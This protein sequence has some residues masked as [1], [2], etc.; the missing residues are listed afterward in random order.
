[1]GKPLNILIVEDSPDDV[2]LLLAELRRAGID[3]KWKRVETEPDFRAEIKKI[4]DIILS[5]YSMPQFN[6]LRAAELVQ[7]L[8]LDIPFILI[9]G[10]V[11]EEIA[12]NAMRHGATDY[13]LK[14][15]ISRLGT[16]IGRALEQKR[17]R[18]EHKKTEQSLSRLQRQHASILNSLAEGVQVIDLEGRIIF[19]N[20][21]SG[22]ML[23]WISADLLGRPAHATSHHSRP[24]GTACPEA[25][26]KINA[27]LRDGITRHVND[28]VF[29]RR[30]GSSFP[31]E[32]I[33][34][35]MRSEDGQIIGVVV[36]F[37]DITEQ[38]KLEA[39][40]RQAQK[41]ESIGQLAGGIAHDFNNILSAIVGNLYLAQQDAANDPAVMGYLDNISK[42]TQRATDLVRQILTFSRKNKSER[43]PLKL[44]HVVLEAL[45][46]LRAS[47]P[48]SIR[49]QTELAETP[50]VL[51]DATAIHQVI[52]NLGTNAWHAMRD[53]PGTLKIE[54]HVIEADEGFVAVH[55]DLRPGRYVQLSVSDTGCGMDRATLER[56]FDPFFTTKEVGEGTGLGLAV[57]HGIMKSHDGGIDVHSQ[58]GKGTV[59]QLYF[60]VVEIKEAGHD[61]T[62]KPLP[63][64]RGE[65]IL[66]VDD[67]EALAGVGKRMLQELGYTVTVKTSA[68]EVIAALRDQPDAFALVITDLTMPVMDGLKLGGQLLQIQPRLP[69]ILMTGYSGMMTSEKVRE[70]GFRELLDKPYTVRSLAESV[71]RVLRQS[72]SAQPA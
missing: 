12:V 54:M 52:M 27:T 22:Q 55:P 16:A 71:D 69:I 19:E 20:V 15:R 36:T 51:A 30:D 29:W 31:V 50:A 11:G 58:P 34:S 9:S 68:P 66:F 42:A 70:L 59:F 64:G 72:A 14:D 24:D 62:L 56:I 26:C 57:V 53:Q 10:T 65:H 18:D 38:R 4:P 25:D 41:M 61:T 5:D 8:G 35:P 3:P 23:G 7:A 63:R 46:L 49:I 28:E 1:M 33:A 13:L 32:Y 60:P 6:G 43:M 2:E 17:L 48:A 39:Q 37:S 44:N 40:F 47:V 45:K 67:E 21:S